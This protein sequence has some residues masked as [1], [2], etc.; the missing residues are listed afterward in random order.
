MIVKNA[1][2]DLQECLAS[3]RG[4]VDETV[5]A[6]TGSTDDTRE[7]AQAAGAHVISIPWEDDFAAARNR[8]LAEVKADWVLMMDADEQLDPAARAEFPALL[9]PSRF[10]GF[11]VAI[12]NYTL[13][14]LMKIW[15]WPAVAN[16]GSYLPARQYPAF[17]EHENVRLFRRDPEIH[18]SGRVHESVGWRMKE[19][20]RKLGAAQ[21]RI[22]H[23]G[24]A[25]ETTESKARK[26]EFYRRLG[27]LKAAEQPENAQAHLEL[28]LVEIENGGAALAALPS[29]LRACELNPNLGV[30]WFFAGAIQFQIGNSARAC[31]SLRRAEEA[32][33]T[34]FA[35]AE[36]AGDANYHLKNFEEARSWYRRAQKRA[37][38]NATIESKLGLAEARAGNAASGIRRLHRAIELEPSNSQLHDRLIVAE[39]WLHHEHEAGEAAEKKLEAVMPRPGDFLRAAAIWSQLREWQRA[40]EI[41]QRGKMSFPESETIGQALNQI[42]TARKAARPEVGAKVQV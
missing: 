21:F 14:P 10:D 1:S 36:L 23:F 18:F 40:K 9:A 31:E 28:G 41:L 15:D 11:Q 6:D 20:R 16:D 38:E 42:E 19:T 29:F 27:R 32:G 2:R 24:M 34:T 12:R 22:H 25:R 7:I 30:A 35:V 4:A 26:L 39:V 8:S 17:V 3:V 5:I 37:P 33:H 13:D